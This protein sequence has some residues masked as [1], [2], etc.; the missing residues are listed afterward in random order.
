MSP[1]LRIWL[2]AEMTMT[3]MTQR[4]V[5]ARGRS[6]EGGGLAGGGF[7]STDRWGNGSVTQFCFCA[8]RS[9]I[10]S[11]S[12]A[13]ASEWDWGDRH[14]FARFL[15]IFCCLTFVFPAIS[16]LLLFSLSLQFCDLIPNCFNSSSFLSSFYPSVFSISRRAVVPH[17]D[18]QMET[19]L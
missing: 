10:P 13:E 6:H 7:V 1:E 14:V 16:F 11:M 8:E 5:S 2:R 18:H 3:A 15:V 12:W 4:C 19:S 17:S 9:F